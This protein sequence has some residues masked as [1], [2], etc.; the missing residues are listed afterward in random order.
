MKKKV[1]MYWLDV[2]FAAAIISQIWL[3]VYSFHRQGWYDERVV[4]SA[5]LTQAWSYLDGYKT[6]L[7]ENWTGYFKDT[8]TGAMFE[9]PISGGVYQTYRSGKR[10]LIYDVSIRRHV[11]DPDVEY[12]NFWIGSGILA[13]IAVIVLSICWGIFAGWRSDKNDPDPKNKAHCPYT[14]Y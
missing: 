10:G 13:I 7:T 5:E 2:L 12:S 11:Y 3:S 6:R 9:Y 14:G 1:K 4:R 8:R